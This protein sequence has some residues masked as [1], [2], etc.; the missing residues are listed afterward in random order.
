M[1][2]PNTDISEHVARIEKIKDLLVS[3]M[4]EFKEKMDDFYRLVHD[5]PHDEFSQLITVGFV[6]GAKFAFGDLNLRLV[7]YTKLLIAELEAIAK[8][9]DSFKKV[10][11]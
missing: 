6:S 4:E 5:F 1:T 10:E 3:N 8:R 7:G 11:D 9:I 2:E